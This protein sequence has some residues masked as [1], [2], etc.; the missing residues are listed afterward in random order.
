[1]LNLFTTIYI[2][3]VRPKVYWLMN[4]IEMFNEGIFQLATIHLFVFSDFVSS[5]EVQYDFG[6]SMVTTMSI[7]IT[8]NFGFV[9]WFGC[10]DLA[11]LIIK[12][13]RRVKR[14]FDPDF[15]RPPK[16]PK[17]CP[18]LPKVYQPFNAIVD[19]EKNGT[20]LAT[21]K[22]AE[23]SKDEYEENFTITRNS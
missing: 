10:S 17:L 14:Y 15:M 18:E 22:E 4:Y 20:D 7:L 8:V 2:G 6:F 16:E 21:I 23:C 19:F 11:L 13:Y 1:M 12:Y 9:I 3:L 5:Q